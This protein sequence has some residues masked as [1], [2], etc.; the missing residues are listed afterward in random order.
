MTCSPFQPSSAT[1]GDFMTSVMHCQPWKNPETYSWVCERR[2]GNGSDGLGTCVASG[3]GSMWLMEY[4]KQWQCPGFYSVMQRYFRRGRGYVG[5]SGR[6]QMMLTH[7]Q[8]KLLEGSLSE[9]FRHRATLG[10][11]CCSEWPHLS[12]VS[13]TA[14]STSSRKTRIFP[15]PKSSRILSKIFFNPNIPPQD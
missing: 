3:W 4:L 2:K 9:V 12:P 11:Q 6:I 13:S 10:W 14:E 5:T 7:K 1:T 8:Q 15:S